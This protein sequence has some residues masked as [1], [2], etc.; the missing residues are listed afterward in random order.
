MMYADAA[1]SAFHASAQS[2]IRRTHLTCGKF[3]K[4]CHVAPAI[5]GGDYAW[6]GFYGGR[7]RQRKRTDVRAGHQAALDDML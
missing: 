5:A 3:G 2:T 7:F 1:R 6:L 4:T